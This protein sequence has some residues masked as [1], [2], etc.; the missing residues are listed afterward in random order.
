MRFLVTVVVIC[1]A[2]IAAADTS[3]IATRAIAARTKTMQAAATAADVDAFLAFVTDDVV[4]EDPVVHMRIEGKAKIRD[5]M[6]GFVGATRAAKTAITKQIAVA[7]VVVLE[8]TVS[9]EQHDGG[10]WVP[11]SRRQ[12]TI[13]ELDDHDKIRRVADYWAR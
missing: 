8:Q 7:N 6:V 3:D 5:G 11:R 1:T 13:I 4:Y 12:V 9:F 10:R 2:S